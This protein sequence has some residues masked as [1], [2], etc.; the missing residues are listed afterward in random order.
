MA[1]KISKTAAYYSLEEIARKLSVHVNTV[2]NLVRARKLPAVKM[3]VQWRVNKSDLVT[4]LEEN[5]KQAFDALP[6]FAWPERPTPPASIAT[7]SDVIY[8]VDTSPYVDEDVLSLF[9]E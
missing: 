5:T 8:P 3:G 6:E 4:Y 7:P 2:R 1:T 9:D